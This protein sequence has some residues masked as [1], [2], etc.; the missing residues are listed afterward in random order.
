MSAF[1]VSNQLINDTL[2]FIKFKADNSRHKLNPL[3]SSLT[4]KFQEKINDLSELEIMKLLG[5]EIEKNNLESYY[6]R[7]P[8]EKGGND[9]SFIYKYNY[10]RISLGQ[11]LK[12]LDCIDYQCCEVDEYENSDFKKLIDRMRSFGINSLDGYSQAKWGY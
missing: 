2:N 12:N 5:E 11:Y 3:K 6:C 1:L 10:S 7:Y 4:M 8:N 9:V